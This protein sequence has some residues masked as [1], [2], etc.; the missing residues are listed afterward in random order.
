MHRFT[1]ILFSPLGDKDNPAAVRRVS[2]LADQN[3]AK[4]TLLGVVPEPT[5][6]Q[7]ALHRP[8]FFDDVQDAE[9]G[10]QASSSGTRP[11]TSSTASTVRSSP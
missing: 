11:R 6:F 7:R 8:H 2:E 9:K 4:L 10:F 5:G 3:G 1:N